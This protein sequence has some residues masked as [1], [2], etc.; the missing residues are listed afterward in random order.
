[1]RFFTLTIISLVALSAQQSFAVYDSEAPVQN[2][3]IKEGGTVLLTE[4][5]VVSSKD[6]RPVAET[7]LLSAPGK[8]L[9]SCAIEFLDA[10][11]EL[12]LQ[13]DESFSFAEK[14]NKY[15]FLKSNKGNRAQVSCSVVGGPYPISSPATPVTLN[16]CFNEDKERRGRSKIFF[17]NLDE[18]PAAPQG[19]KSEDSGAVA[20]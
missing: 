8:R 17:R 9:V 10:K 1:M 16:K 20:P 13:Q 12:T 6:G 4:K 19:D 2:T 15:I 3:P 5:L 7:C 11:K 14:N 18:A